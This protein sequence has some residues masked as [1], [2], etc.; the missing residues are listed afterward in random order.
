MTLQRAICNSIRPY[1]WHSLL[2]ALSLSVIV[3]IGIVWC[4]KEYSKRCCHSEDGFQRELCKLD[5]VFFAEGFS[6]LKKLKLPFSL[7][8]IALY[9][10]FQFRLSLM[11]I[12]RYFVLSTLLI[13]SLLR[14]RSGKSLPILF[15]C[16]LWPMTIY[17]LLLEFKLSLSIIIQFDIFSSSFFKSVGRSFKFLMRYSHMYHQHTYLGSCFLENSQNH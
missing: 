16:R 13:T 7:F 12:H 15:S 8:L 5:Q 3:T 10:S 17:S 4:W 2:A 6:F 11:F 14:T 9:C 1:A